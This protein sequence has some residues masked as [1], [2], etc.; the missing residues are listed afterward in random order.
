MPENLLNSDTAKDSEISA[1][2]EA[3]L[4]HA[5]ACLRTE[6]AALRLITR[7]EQCSGGLARKLEKRGH[8]SSCVKAVIDRLLLLRLINDNR[9]AQLWLESRLRLARSPRCILISLCSKGIDR[10]DA[11]A[12]LKAVLDDDTEYAVLLRFVKKRAKK[13]KSGGGDVKRSLKHM[14][15]NEGFSYAAIQRF[16]DEDQT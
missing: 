10:D 14:L 16:L 9:F 6:K 1:Y 15:K 2:E 12:A 11:D 3:A 13:I 8:D 5:S 4:R 7:A